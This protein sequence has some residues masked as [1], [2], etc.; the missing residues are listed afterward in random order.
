VTA[1]DTTS[2]NNLKS[3]PRFQ[4]LGMFSQVSG[5]RCGSLHCPYDNAICCSPQG[6]RRGSCCPGGYKC[7]WP[8]SGP[9]TCEADDSASGSSGG[10]TVTTVRPTVIMQGQASAGSGA[11]SSLAGT[12][13]A[14][15]QVA[16]P[17]TA[18]QMSGLASLSAPGVPSSLSATNSESGGSSVAPAPPTPKF[19]QNIIIVKNINVLTKLQQVKPGPPPSS[20]SSGSGSSSGSSGS[21]SGSSGSLSES[22]FGSGSS[23]RASGSSSLSA[24]QSGSSQPRLRSSMSSLS[25][26]ES[27]EETGEE[28]EETVE[29]E[30]SAEAV[31]GEESGSFSASQSRF[32]QRP[33]YGEEQ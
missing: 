20:Q 22:S 29:E 16:P 19:R 24:S 14:F 8:D 9:T 6:G 3:Y 28:E 10:G 1:V 31:S 15:G 23:S 25:G 2:A 13:S 11:A 27:D 30:E 33:T 18:A 21:S 7:T 17:S 26:S 5:T 32:M 12:G 4:Q